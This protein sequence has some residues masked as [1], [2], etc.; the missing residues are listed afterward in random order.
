ML[1][2]AFGNRMRAAALVPGLSICGLTLLI[3]APALILKV[4]VGAWPD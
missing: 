1:S 3:T 2:G 4:G